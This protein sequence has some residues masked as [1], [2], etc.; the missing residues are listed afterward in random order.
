MSSHAHT[1]N[2]IRQWII[3]GVAASVGLIATI[4]FV[5]PPG[6]GPGEAEAATIG[7]DV[8]DVWFCDSSFQGGVCETTVSVGDTVE[9]TQTGGLPHTVS[10]CTDATYTS[11]NSG[12]TK[13]FAGG[14]SEQFSQTFGTD[15]TFYYRCNI[16][17]GPMR[18]R[19]VVGS[20][21][22][23]TDGD[24]IPDGQDPDDDNDG[25]PDTYEQENGCLDPL[26]DDAAVDS[27]G[28]GLSN[29]AE[30]GLGTDPCEPDTDGDGL[31][32]GEDEF[33]LDPD[34]PA[35]STPSLTDTPSPSDSPAPT[36]EPT[37]TATASPV[38][39]AELVWGDIDC[40]GG[41]NSVDALK[42]LR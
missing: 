30:M 40:N 29:I 8:G 28:D 42:D 37:P 14:S 12:F 4:V 23:D 5:V 22:L 2:R 27:D 7:V 16:H 11:C 15:G 3:F 1:G 31:D 20:G 24:T 13:T 32:D 33:P 10:Q 34:L 25:M 9:W 19:I 41:V 36:E 39:G 18:G 35:T 17:P 38:P 21:G 26:T 6:N